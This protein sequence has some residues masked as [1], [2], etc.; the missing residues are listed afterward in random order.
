MNNNF[1]ELEYLF[2]VRYYNLYY[3]R[4]IIILFIF[5]T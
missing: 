3:E 4:I 1:N 2:F 5:K